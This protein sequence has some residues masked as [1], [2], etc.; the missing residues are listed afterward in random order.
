MPPAP[1]AAASEIL[2]ARRSR[3]VRD[4]ARLYIEG[5]ANSYSIQ[6]GTSLPPV[7]RPAVAE[8]IRFGGG[9]AAG[10]TGILELVEDT[11]VLAARFPTRGLHFIPCVL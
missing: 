8:I 11:S 4:G 2:R 10:A 7:I 5:S 6:P 1:K 9:Q 3:I